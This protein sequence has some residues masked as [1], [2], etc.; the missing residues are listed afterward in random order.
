MPSAFASGALAAVLALGGVATTATAPPAPTTPSTGPDQLAVV[1]V[2]DGET[3]ANVAGPVRIDLID[4]TGAAHDSLDLPTQ[5]DGDQH[6]LTLGVDRDQ[7]G[8]L[9]QSADRSYV[10]LGGYDA[11]LGADTNSSLAPETLRVVG[12]IGVDGDVDTSTTLAGAYSERHVRG[13]ASADGQWH[14]TGGHGNDSEDPYWAGMFTV[15][16]GGDTP[17]VVATDADSDASNR[18]NNTRVPVIHDGQLFVSSD[19]SGYHGINRVGDG[20][21]T[22]PSALT[23]VAAAPEGSSVPHDFAFVGDHLYVTYTDGDAALVRYEE[24]GGEWTVNGAFP[25]EFWGVTGRTAGEDTVLYAVR[26]SDAG[27]EVVAL[28]DEADGEFVD[29]RLSTITVAE[30]NTAFRGIAFAPGFTPGDG[31]VE[32]DFGP[33]ARWDVR[34]PGGAGNALSAVLGAD[35]N[36][37]ATGTMSDPQ[38]EAFTVEVTSA[39]QD[40]V[41]DEDITLTLA[42]DG[43][44]TLAADPVGTGTTVLTLTA[45]TEDG[46][47]S[48][49]QISYW[50]S[51]PITE[52][53]ALAHVGMADASAAYDA[54][55]GHL[56][57]ADDDSNQIRLYGPTFG[58][59]VTWFDFSAQMQ[60]PT[61]RA[62]DLEGAARADDTIYW[63][64]S[65]GNSRSGNYWPHRDVVLATDVDGSGAGTVLTFAGEATGFRDA[66][67]EWDNS[68][69]HEEGAG[70]FQFERALSD[71]WSAEGPN[72]LNVEGATIAP[73]GTTLWLGFRSPLVPVAQ[74]PGVDPDGDLALIIGIE[75]IAEVVDGADIVVGQHHLLDLDGRAIRDLTETADGSGYLIAAG[76]ADDTGNFAVYRWSGDPAEEPEISATPLG[77]EGWEGS[78]EAFGVVPSLADG[79][80]IRVMQDVGTLDLYGTGT[81][82]QDLTREHMKFVSHDYELVFE[83]SEAP[84][85]DRVAGTNRY[86]TAAQLALSRFEP[87]VETVF[88]ANGL[89]FPDAV[90]GGALAVEQEGPVLLTR[91]EAL[92]QSTVAAL[93][94]L[95]PQ[96]VVVLGGELVVE[97]AVLEELGALV[98][99]VDRVAGLDRYRT[100]AAIAQEWDSSDVVFLASGQDYPDALS[101]AAAAGVE[102]APVLLTRQ[103]GLPGAT[104]N[105]LERLNPSVIYV[106]GGEIAV[107]D[108]AAEQAGE[109]AEV[110]RLGGQN[111]YVTSS[112]VA[113]EFFTAPVAEAFLATGL[114]YPDALAAAP[115]AAL[116]VG[117]VLLTRPGSVPATT[118]TA[119][120]AVRAEAVTLLG[121]HE[122]I[123]EQVEEFLEGY[124]YP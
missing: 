37:V 30:P 12:R 5:P 20:I 45:T 117:P 69:A 61:D 116:S 33:Q 88:V 86:G 108:E 9:Q 104:M 13:V 107:S 84:V 21:P 91:T 89:D 43:S 85:V 44:F 15:E 119:L 17:Q 34:V 81:E 31:P 18:Q 19:R 58:E 73:D 56:L 109:Y 110:V 101:A 16:H 46:R 98:P 57:V 22:E 99:V 64:G 51:A 67:V 39:D 87:G 10:T 77:L 92:A 8:A 72:S 25:G 90:A 62:F 40:V 102:G 28:L 32:E 35:T 4:S 124:A 96:R 63:V 60:H 29:A 1:T 95:A 103:H 114:E 94:E 80:V 71:G 112:A 48:T 38:G 65:L 53:S 55:D 122:A 82:A 36:P 42:A 68:N 24:Q 120:N 49:T 118:L 6:R 105:E 121:G 100:A 97:P 123:S 26:G 66:L 115:V 75:N 78:Y 23:L 106:I 11:E 113:Q 111:R 2:G 70:A 83:P 41:A 50:V 47:T 79:T 3:Y 93:E 74:D 76:S 59:P 7:A 54:G 14:W 52:P 27:N